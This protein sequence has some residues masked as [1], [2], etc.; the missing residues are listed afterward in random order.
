[1]TEFPMNS[2]VKLS[3]WYRKHLTE[4]HK[5]NTPVNKEYYDELLASSSFVYMGE[6]DNMPGHGIFVSKLGRVFWGFHMDDFELEADEDLVTTIY[7]DE[8][9]ILDLDEE[10]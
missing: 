7:I 4:Y 6:I 8:E 10:E 2:I 1:M 9:D 3:D 5:E